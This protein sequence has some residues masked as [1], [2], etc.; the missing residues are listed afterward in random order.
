[1]GLEKTDLI[2]IIDHLVTEKAMQLRQQKKT[3]CVN[4]WQAIQ[5]LG[6]KERKF[7][8]I[9]KDPKC[10]IRKG[11]VRGSFIESSVYKERDRFN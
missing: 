10:L 9:L 7:Y 11:S 2:K 5:I 3:H 6:C 4:K 8:D 1:M